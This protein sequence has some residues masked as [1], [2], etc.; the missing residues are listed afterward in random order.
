[1]VG[2]IS[3]DKFNIKDMLKLDNLY[4]KKLLL[5]AYYAAV[6]IAVVGMFVSIVNGFIN[7]FN[8]EVLAGIWGIISS[9]FLLVFKVIIIRVAAEVI[10]AIFDIKNKN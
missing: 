8:D 5:I 7:L 9:P 1:M 2:G 3:M 4:E 6:I 10:A